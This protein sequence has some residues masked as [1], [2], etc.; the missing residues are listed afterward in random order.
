[1]KR[2]QLRL[3]FAFEWVR[4]RTPWRHR[5]NLTRPRPNG[6]TESPFASYLETMWSNTIASYT[7]FG[8]AKRIRDIDALLQHFATN[9]SIVKDKG[10][11]EFGLPI[12]LFF[13]AHSAFRAGAA[14]GLSGAIVES[15]PVLRLCL[16]TAGYASM[17]NG[18]EALALVWV[19]RMEDEQTKRAARNAFKH[20]DVIR[21]LKAKEGTIAGYYEG[22]Y[23]SL[24]DTGAHPNEFG[25]MTSMIIQ[26]LESGGRVY[27]QAYLQ[28]DS[29]YLEMALMATGQ[30]SVCILMIF[31]KMYPQIFRELGITERIPVVA[32][33]I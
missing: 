25:F 30:V 5:S 9:A 33:G 29:T 27:G 12:L 28:N 4:E 26:E 24:I 18:D 8:N 14:L 2:L 15:M 17:I 22:I 10:R 3:R 16:E 20:S 13:R 6:W 11:L 1:M 21:S 7:G 23:D 31:E 32:S 19:K